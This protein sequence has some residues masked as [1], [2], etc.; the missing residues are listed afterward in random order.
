MCGQRSNVL[1][2]YGSGCGG[3]IGH[4][5]GH[6]KKFQAENS[7]NDDWILDEYSNIAEGFAPQRLNMGILRIWRDCNRGFVSVA[8]STLPYLH[9]FWNFSILASGYLHAV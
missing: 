4:V 1:D 6:A 2:S 9:S 8:M 7:A 5:A 3:M